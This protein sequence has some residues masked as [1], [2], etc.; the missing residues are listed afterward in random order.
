MILKCIIF[1]MNY[2]NKM[3]YII[4]I[5]I[6]LKF[7]LILVYQSVIFNKNYKIIWKYNNKVWIVLKNK[8]IK[9]L[10]EL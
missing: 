7:K 1:E 8:L 3:N 4:L 5:K 10:K 6:N 2:C 9:S